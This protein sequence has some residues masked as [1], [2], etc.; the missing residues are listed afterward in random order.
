MDPN[1]LAKSGSEHAH[2]TAFFQALLTWSPVVH[3]VTFAIPNGAAL[4]E[5]GKSPQARLTGAIRMNRLKAE[6]LKTGVP[7]VF[8]AWPINGYAGLFLEFKV[9]DKGVISDDQKLWR[10]N[11]MQHCYQ[12]RTVFNWQEAVNAVALYFGRPA[13]Y[14]DVGNGF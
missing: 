2:Q 13:Q 9:A 14:A 3:A 1:K 12:V 5:R 8:V 7:D 6:G 4:A 11:L 10:A